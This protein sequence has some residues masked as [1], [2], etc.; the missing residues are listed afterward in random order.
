MSDSF[1]AESSERATKV[2]AAHLL[3]VLTSTA[4]PSHQQTMW[5]G[6]AGRSRGPWRLTPGT[7]VDASEIASGRYC[8]GCT[9][10]TRCCSFSRIGCFFV[11]RPA[12]TRHR[13]GKYQSRSAFRHVRVRRRRCNHSSSVSV[14]WPKR[15][16]QTAALSS[17]A[18]QK[19]QRCLHEPS[20]ETNCQ[21][22]QCVSTDSNI[23]EGHVLLHG[24]QAG[25]SR[26][27]E[28][29]RDTGMA[30]DCRICPK[31]CPG[32]MRPPS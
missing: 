13:G 29:R 10:T 32:Y 2:S 15:S 8:A 31:R 1:F 20:A 12:G 11:A 3:K 7:W 28:N 22:G 26:P 23:L 18:L 14:E 17:D 27:E 21:F 9:D 16:I 19:L 5:S 4:P 6:R 24:V 25:A 30:E